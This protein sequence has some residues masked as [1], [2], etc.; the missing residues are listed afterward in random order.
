M[1]T[2]MVGMSGS[3]LNK[4]VNL[5]YFKDK[6]MQKKEPHDKENKRKVPGQDLKTM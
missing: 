1:C 6:G 2:K 4:E 5:H 3:I